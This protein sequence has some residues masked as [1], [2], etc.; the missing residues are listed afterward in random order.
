MV[1]M[2]TSLVHPAALVA[3]DT[4][5]SQE[6]LDRAITMFDAGKRTAGSATGFHGRD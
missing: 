2:L 1:G 6:S 3:G 4:L 5:Y